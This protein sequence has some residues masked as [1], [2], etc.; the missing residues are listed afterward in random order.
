MAGA[1]SFVH[2][3]A[4]LE[5]DPV[6]VHLADGVGLRVPLV[7]RWVPVWY[8]AAFTQGPHCR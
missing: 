7:R 3:E 1:A 8:L 4:H 6:V 5:Y 2:A